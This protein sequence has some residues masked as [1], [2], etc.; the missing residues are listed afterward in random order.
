MIGELRGDYW[1]EQTGFTTTGPVGLK[2][3]DLEARISD[4]GAGSLRITSLE[5]GSPLYDAFDIYG[6]G[7]ALA[8][9]EL[10][11]MAGQAIGSLQELD[12]CLKRIR[13]HSTQARRLY[14][15][16]GRPVRIGSTR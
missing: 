3:I 9:D 8:L 6:A 12:R 16:T 10:V 1:H 13:A 5:T 11:C 4:S 14:R 7:S 15:E 2:R